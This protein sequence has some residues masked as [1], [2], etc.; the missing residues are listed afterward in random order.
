M[1]VRVYEIGKT[2]CEKLIGIKA[3]CELEFNKYL[4]S[5]IWKG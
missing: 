5:F 3:D 2:K 1:N 4:D